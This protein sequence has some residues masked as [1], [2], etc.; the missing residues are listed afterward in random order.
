MDLN[1]YVACR[2]CDLLHRRLP[3]HTSG[4]AH[5]TRCGAIL[6]RSRRKSLDRTLAMS[7]TGVVLLLL[8]NLFPFLAL[9][10]EGQVRETLLITGIVQLYRQGLPMVASLVLLTGILFPLI[11]LAGLVYILLPLKFN[12]RPWRMVTIFL[13]IRGI[14][15]WAMIE[16]F[17]L[18]VLIALVKLL[19]MATIV[20]G[21]ALYAFFLLSFVVAAAAASLNADSIWR[22][23]TLRQ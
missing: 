9:N 11:E 6:Y 23:L 22:Q 21:V 12:H 14:Q 10:F 18:G 15:P 1:A 2:Q 3:L 8:A 19:D 4:V 17:V 20:P 13:L 7:A 16:V 5:C